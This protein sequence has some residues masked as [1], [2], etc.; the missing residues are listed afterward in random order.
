MNEADR[1]PDGSSIT[2]VKDEDTLKTWCYISGISFGMPEQAIPSLVE[3]FSTDIKLQQPLKFYLGL[4]DGKPVATSMYYLAEGVAGIYFVATLTEARNKGIGFAI[5]Q[6]P[7]LEAREMG[8][9]V[10]IL[11]ASKM[12]EP[13]YR[14]LGFKEYSHIGSYSWIYQPSKGV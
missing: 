13:V 5:T 9:K 7:L 6:K 10:G 14:R 4:L 12:G 3:Y 2:E 11:Q 8:Y 1:A